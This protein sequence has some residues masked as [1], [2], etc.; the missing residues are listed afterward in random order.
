MNG[1]EVVR[2]ERAMD[3]QADK[4]G[5]SVRDLGIQIDAVGNRVTRVETR[6]EDHIDF[7]KPEVS[8]VGPAPTAPIEGNVSIPI[9][10]LV[11]LIGL[12][13]GGGSGIAKLL[14]MLGAM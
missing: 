1:E 8:T 11:L 6:L 4:I 12:A 13:V 14:Q 10:W 2:I 7:A 5:A 9:R 3:R